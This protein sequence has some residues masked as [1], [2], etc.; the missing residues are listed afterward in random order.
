MSFVCSE[1]DSSDGG[2]DDSQVSQTLIDLEAEDLNETGLISPA[3]LVEQGM[4]FSI[5]LR[6]N[7][8][9]V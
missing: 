8:H 6:W 1:D 3:S 4:V 9:R 2:E 5:V 7:I